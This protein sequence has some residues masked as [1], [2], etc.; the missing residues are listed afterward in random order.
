MEDKC[1]CCDKELKKLSDYPLVYIKDFKRIELPSDLVFPY[2]DH[3]IYVE[4]GHPHCNKKVP[5][6]VFDYFKKNN[7]AES[8]EFEEWKW[9]KKQG[10]HYY[11]SQ[12]DQREL[13]VNNLK[14]YFD[15]LESYVGKEVPTKE[16]LPPFDK[17]GYFNFAYQIPDTAYPIM[18]S[19][20]DNPPEDYKISVIKI[21]GEG[22]N[23]GSAGGP[24]LS[25]LANLA[26]VEYEGR[27]RK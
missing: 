9:T 27:L 2:H 20:I 17:D 16:F 6:E 13:I 10:D 25:S 23:F 1:P 11:R 7:K 24:T 26:K 12:D 21:M 3:E 22:P 19:D 8:F 14:D 4:P 15:K 18:F 5:I